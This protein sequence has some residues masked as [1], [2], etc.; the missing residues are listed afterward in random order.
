MRVSVFGL[1]YVGSVTAACLAEAGNDVL[2]VDPD[3]SL[4]EE[5]LQ[6]RPPVSATRFA[7]TSPSRSLRFFVPRIT[8]QSISMCQGLP[9]CLGSVTRK[10]SPNPCRYIRT[11]TPPRGAI[12]G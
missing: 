1:G 3:A 7:I 10:Q 8:P 11:T 6:G 12:S 2:G 9:S 4:V 5:L